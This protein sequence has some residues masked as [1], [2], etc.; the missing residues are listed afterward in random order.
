MFKQVGNKLLR[1]DDKEL[2]CIEPWGKNA[3]RVRATQ[4]DRFQDDGI[5]SALLEPAESRAE[6]RIDDQR[7]EII[8]G[9]IR[10]E[11]MSTGK[12]RFYNHE[13]KLLLE[14]YD[15]NR[16]RG[17]VEE[18]FN[19]ALEIDPRTFEPHRG[20]DNYQLTVRFE[21]CD[22]EKI[23]GMGQYQQPYLNLKG[24]ILELAQR[25]S[26]A[27]VPFALSSKGYGML[28]NNPAV[29]KVTFGKNLTEWIAYSTKQMDYWITAGDNP[30]EIV[31]NYADVTGKVPM[32]PDWAMGFWQ[33]KLRYQTQEE[34]MEVARE[35]KR[36]GLPI[37][38][39]V[40]DYFHW[41]YQGDWKF[42]R[43]YWPDPEKM[44]KELR[45]MGIQL[46][47]SIWPTVEQDSENYEEM[48]ELG[49][50]VR[51]EAGK[52]LGQLGN[53]CF[54]DMTNPDARAYVWNK[55]KKNYY[56]LGIRIFWLDE[57]EPEFTD[58]EYSHYR[59][60]LGSVLEIGNLY[61]K[62]YAKMAYDGMTAEGQEH[63]INLIRCAWAGSQR[64]GALVWSGDIDSSFRALRNQLAAGLNMGLAGIPW[65]TTDIGG[66][67]GGNIH[68]DK[69]KELLVRWF[70]FGAFSP[71]FRLHGCREPMKKPIGTTGGGKVP[72]GADNEVWSYGEEVYEI[73]RKYMEI[74]EK[75]RPYIKTLMQEA[76]EKGTPVMRPLF[77][78]FPKDEKAWEIE[79]QYMFGSDIMVC[80]ILYEGMREREVYLP[81]GS[82]WSMVDKKVYEGGRVMTC[83]APIDAMP[84]FVKEG[85]LQTVFGG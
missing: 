36:R 11:V 75:M 61:P 23:Y 60:H 49:Y 57:A 70:Q 16:F 68:S 30:A 39:I 72:S 19:S 8:N 34:I 29:G 20:T 22:D 73:C 25:N 55:I 69:F 12:L 2:L 26:Q 47:V 37:S 42:D 82:W 35:Y 32:M 48:R 38:V 54:V 53:A 65:W 83:P 21:A 10:C 18:E 78:D 27:S 67:H 85:R 51:S 31:E 46:M 62:L 14:E 5:Y 64:Y 76:H 3:L 74:R 80:P 40:V 66:F 63:V 9:K 77:Y 17:N 56:D 15:R 84:V 4:L 45:E 28:W 79:D 58:Y 50:L 43:C 7:A 44:V 41:P 1:R 13:N 6:I 33:C 71:V 81:E 59:Y 24:C 52:R